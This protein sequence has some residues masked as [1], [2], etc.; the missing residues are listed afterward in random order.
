MRAIFAIGFLSLLLAV[1]APPQSFAQVAHPV[2]NLRDFGAV[3]DG[4][5]DDT[6]AVRQWLGALTPGTRGYAPAGV[7]VI[8]SPLESATPRI[9]IAGDGPYQTIFAYAGTDPNV[10]ILTIENVVNWQISGLRVT[11]F[12]RMSGGAAVHLKRFCR[13]MIDQV[14]IDGQDGTKNLWNGIWFDAVDMV[15]YRN[16]DIKAQNDAVMVN[17][18]LGRQ[19]KADLMLE[20]GKIGGS[21]VGLRVGGAFG[22]LCIDQ[23]DIIGNGRNV[24]I[25]N[26][27]AHEG[28]R[29][30]FFGPAAMIDSAKTGASITLADTLAGTAAWL[31]FSGTWI[32]SGT[33]DGFLSVP[34][35]RWTVQFTGGNIFNFGRDGI[36][37]ESQKIRLYFNGTII[38]NNRGYGVQSL[39][40]NDT[41]SLIDIT[42]LSNAAGDYAHPH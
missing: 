21:Q 32:A 41:I 3:G 6:N 25:D 14:V 26:S 19:P 33:T 24:V 34:D 38:R 1:S 23:T 12:T 8:H 7:Y 39:V 11:A 36:H 17:G 37:N 35:V 30:I 40:P 20:Q 27:L 28:N 2:L 13:S 5:A 9:S 16:F 29:E 42:Y 4:K 10:D 18:G 22:G 15:T 31:E